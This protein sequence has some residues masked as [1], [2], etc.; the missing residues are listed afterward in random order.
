MA[1]SIILTAFQIIQSPE[2]TAL[3]P[4]LPTLSS[5]TKSF[6]NC[7]YHKFFQ[8]LAPVETEFFIPSRL[9]SPHPR[10]YIREMKVLAYSQLL[11]SYRSLTISTMR[12]W[13]RQAP[14][15]KPYH[16]PS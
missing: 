6:Y 2:I 12:W 7:H 4:S 15:T 13:A 16:H 8:A 1:K 14:A 3:L 5:F 11:E 10:W 9:L